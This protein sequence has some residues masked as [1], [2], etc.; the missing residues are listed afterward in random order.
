MCNRENNGEMKRTG[1]R[2]II[3]I[4]C[5][6]LLSG[7]VAV[8]TYMLGKG[9][10]RRKDMA[11]AERETYAASGQEDRQELN[12]EDNRTYLRQVISIEEIL[13]EGMN[14]LTDEEMDWE[15]EYV[16]QAVCD[17][18]Q[19][20]YD[21]TLSRRETMEIT[22]LRIPKAEQV[23]TLH[24]L[25][26][27]PQLT[28]L[29]LAG[30]EGE[31][32]H[33]DLEP[34]MVPMLEELIFENIPL[35]EA[36]FLEELPDV[37]ALGMI[38][39]GL[40]N[41]SFLDK[42]PRLTEVTFYG[43]ELRDISPLADCKELEV[44]SLAYNR[45]TDI[46]VLSQLANL[47]EVGLQ[48]NRIS[49]IEGLGNL[50]RLEA[51]NLNSNQIT[52]L[53]PLEGLKG[54]TALGAADNQIE[55]ISPLEG[56]TKM[57][58]LSLDANLISDIS[59]LSDMKEMQYLGL[60]R[61]QIEDY[62]PIME[63]KKLYSLSV[64]D[65][66]GQNIGKLVF[67]PWL[68][69]GNTLEIEEEEL[70]QMQAYLE[71]YYPEKGMQ[72]EDFAKGD[73][74]GDGIEDLAVTALLDE[75]EDSE[76]GAV[77]KRCVYPF[78]GRGGGIFTPLT[79]VETLHPDSGG[80]YGDP[81]AGIIITGDMLVIQVYG[82][83][84]WRWGSTNMYQ[85]E[86]GN[87]VAKWETD[88]G[89]FVF[90]T[91]MDYTVRNLEN[92]QWKHYVAVGDAEREKELLL[93]AEDNGEADPRKEELDVL[94]RQLEEE[95]QKPLPEVRAGVMAP[96]LDGWFDY[97]IYDYDV[98]REPCWV[99]EKAAEEFLTNA[100]PLPAV[101]YTSQEIRTSYEKLMG[102]APPEQF[103][104]GLME[105][106]PVLLYYNSCVQEKAGFIHEL[107]LCRPD[108]EGEYWVEDHSIYYDESTGR[109]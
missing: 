101:Y 92:G 10:E 107:I 77:R 40:N 56:M 14:Y 3:S 106:E 55:D 105:G 50:G 66:P 31:E 59:V 63:M 53:S 78:I 2:L 39:C 52:D 103:Y 34:E 74:N 38:D 82:G 57:Y 29:T 84:N 99:L 4:S 25:R 80:V 75:E 6:V 87:M 48:G 79:P 41:I 20:S 61:N 98:T 93:I 71:L 44:V 26:K 28:S 30:T 27:L 43:N 94:L 64:E 49:D 35:G 16:R 17:E 73:L 100:R 45:L 33:F 42:Y 83:S 23:K 47:K 21:S 109:F 36:D 60:S 37:K 9:I 91:G 58:N 76:F 8:F 22:A 54:L 81:Y 67:T 1:K 68:L 12:I 86:G 15:D 90:T 95:I 89:H 46:S 51:V 24:D 7:I 5:L 62:T 32:I 65:N 102:V 72:A 69:M 13:A 104:I 88:I 11:D 108:E 18:I 97:H 19:S 70:A 85:Y 96:E